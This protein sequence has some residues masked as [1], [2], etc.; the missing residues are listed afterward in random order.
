M[1]KKEKERK[2][3]RETDREREREKERERDKKREKKCDIAAAWGFFESLALRA[4]VVSALMSAIPVFFFP[5]SSFLFNELEFDFCAIFIP[6]LW[7]AFSRIKKQKK[8]T[9]KKA[10]FFFIFLL[11]NSAC[12]KKKEEKKEREGTISPFIPLNIDSHIAASCRWICMPK[13]EFARC[14]STV[15]CQIVM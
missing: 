10:F 3:E 9:D 4:I 2:R 11:R 7:N 15:E 13:H 14:T 6:A 1:K 12:I 8:K 5:L